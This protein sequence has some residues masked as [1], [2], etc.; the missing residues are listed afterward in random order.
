MERPF[1]SGDTDCAG[2]LYLPAGS[3]QSKVPCIIL[4][5]GFGGVRRMLTP[6]AAAFQA[7]GWAAFVFDYRNFG[8]SG[9][10]MRQVVNI[11]KQLDDWRAAISHVRSMPEVDS[12]RIAIW[13]SSLGG[14]HVLS[15]AAEDHQLRA[16]IAQAP[17]ISGWAAFKAIGIRHALRLAPY[18][19]L[20]M[21]KRL[22]GLGGFKL[23]LMGRPGT[24]AIMTGDDGSGFIEAAMKL[25]PGTDTSVAAASVLSI[26]RYFPALKAHQ[27]AC[28]LLMLIANRDGTTPAN[29]ALAVAQNIRNITVKRYECGHFEVYLDPVFQQAVDAQVAFLKDHL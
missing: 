16:A 9:G 21:L 29:A 5:H 19:I 10:S 26:A 23:D 13:G 8:D 11:S 27:I 17:H 28:P 12:D 14:G 25:A 4:A 18:I 7:Q 22:I 15:I 24:R 6:Y 1:S 2:T 3:P 20:D